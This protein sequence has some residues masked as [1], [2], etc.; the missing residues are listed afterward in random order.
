HDF[1]H[2]H[3]RNPC[4]VPNMAHSHSLLYYHFVFSTKHRALLI[5]AEL[6][7]RL[8]A[9]LGGI[10]KGMEGSAIKVG[11]IEDH[12]HMLVRLPSTIAPA[13]A[14]RDIKANSSG[15]VHENFPHRQ[16]FAWQR[17]YGAFT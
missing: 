12:V 11:G 13:D 15:W 16:Q 10:V 8:H 3:D 7:V 14:I 5:D 9:Y 17:G 4:R 6:E 1:K 2:N